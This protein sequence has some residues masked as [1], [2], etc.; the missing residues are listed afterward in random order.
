[1]GVPEE[2]LLFSCDAMIRCFKIQ[3]CSF[4][5]RNYSMNKGFYPHLKARSQPRNEFVKAF[6]NHKGHLSAICQLRGGCGKTRQSVA[7][8]DPCTN[9][10]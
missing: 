10:P 4:W 5:N 8:L 6:D 1:L 9:S 2:L 7:F 3:V